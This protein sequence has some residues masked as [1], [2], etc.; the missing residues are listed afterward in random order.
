MHALISQD[1]RIQVIGEASS[2]EDDEFKRAEPEVIV[3]APAANISY[4]HLAAELNNAE[5]DETASVLLI[6]DEPK[7]IEALSK[8][9]ARAWGMLSTDFTQAELLAAISA[10][11]EGLIV[12]D[13]IWMQYLPSGQAINREGSNDMVETLTGRELEVLQL[14]ALGL[15]NKQIALRLGIS[16]HT[17]K[18]H[19]SSLFTKM[20]T[21]NRTETVKLG[22]TMGL[23]VL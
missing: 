7:M 10:L 8:T 21:T 5:L 9:R 13:P 14:L 4:D 15:T 2:L 20:G 16:A 1:Q 3:W 22:L 6:H 23:I 12:M 11:Y 18:F 17:V 19:I